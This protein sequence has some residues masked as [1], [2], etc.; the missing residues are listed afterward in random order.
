MNRRF[1]AARVSTTL[2]L[3]V[4]VLAARPARAA[5]RQ[6]FETESYV[7][8]VDRVE[9]HQDVVIVHLKLDGRASGVSF[10]LGDWKQEGSVASSTPRP[11]GVGSGLVLVDEAGRVFPD[12]SL[13]VIGPRC[14]GARARC[15]GLRLENHKVRMSA[16]FR[17]AG[18]AAAPLGV[19]GSVA[20]SKDGFSLRGVERLPNGGRPVRIDGIHAGNTK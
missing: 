1:P 14:L 12:E 15:P 10:A 3:A 9:R 16:L 4:L 20:A 17:V 11:P 6:T 19:V 8:E 7:L 2:T 18:P 5:E 13:G